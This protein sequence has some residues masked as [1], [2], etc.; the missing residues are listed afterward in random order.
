MNEPVILPTRFLRC[1]FKPD[2]RPLLLDLSH[3]EKAD[4]QVSTARHGQGR[5]KFA[6]E[7]PS[8]IAF[9]ERLSR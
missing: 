4:A 9:L 5:W 8:F 7:A 6:L 1:Q 2:W 3:I